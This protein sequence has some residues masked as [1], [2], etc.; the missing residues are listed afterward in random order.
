MGGT[1]V[2]AVAGT[3]LRFAALA[4]WP[5]QAGMFVSTVL[6]VGLGCAVVGAAD[7][8]ERTST[9]TAV[10]TGAAG[11]AASISLVAVVAAIS[12]PPWCVAYL[13]SCPVAAALGLTSGAAAA[14]AGSGA[15]NRRRNPVAGDD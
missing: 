1:L 13:M 15:L 5:S 7:V 2:G 14:G 11:A 9:A 4:A 12:S 8:L 6:F 3:V 10:A